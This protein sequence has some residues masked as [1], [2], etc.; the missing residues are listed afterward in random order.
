MQRESLKSDKIEISFDWKIEIKINGE[1]IVEP[2]RNKINFR[3]KT[4]LI[5]LKL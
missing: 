1:I 2:Q 4:I 3:L 5:Q